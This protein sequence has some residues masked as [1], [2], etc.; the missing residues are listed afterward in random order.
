VV[1]TLSPEHRARLRESNVGRVVSPETRAKMSASNM[2]KTRSAET[3][4]R[5]SES[6]RGRVASPET[7]AKRSEFQTGKTLPPETRAKISESLKKHWG[8]L[9]DEEKE[10]RVTKS[11]DRSGSYSQVGETLRTQDGDL[12]QLCLTTIDFSLPYNHKMARTVDHIVPTRQGGSSL[13]DNLWLAHR[14]C[15]A[16]KRASHVGRSDGST[17]RRREVLRRPH[18]VA[19]P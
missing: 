17:D 1:K 13:L 4:A 3:R 6:Q 18:A 5:I 15:N 10:A 7:R 14:S 2:G 12:C 19:A 9:C 16:R 11:R 8:S